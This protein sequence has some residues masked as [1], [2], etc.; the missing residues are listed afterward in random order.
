MN[1]VNGPLTLPEL[2]NQQFDYSGMDSLN[3][4][5]DREVFTQWPHSIDY[6]YNSRGFRDQEWPED[7]ESAVWCLG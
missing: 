7:L 3:R 2:A 5:L 4:C 1:A 6:R